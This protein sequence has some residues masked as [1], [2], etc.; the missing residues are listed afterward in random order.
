M[1][2]SPLVQLLQAQVNSSMLRST[3][4]HLLKNQTS[5]NAQVWLKREDEQPHGSKQRKYA[6][7]IPALLRQ[8]IKAVALLGSM[9]SN[10][11]V[12]IT[13]LLRQAGIQ[14]LLVLREG[15]ADHKA[16]NPLLLRLLTSPA[17]RKM[18]S[19]ADWPQAAQLAQEWLDQLGHSPHSLVLPEGGF[20]PWAL[21]GALTLGVELLEQENQLGFAFDHLVLDAGT[22]LTAAAL[23]LSGAL[24]GRQWPL[25][26]L[27]RAESPEA[28]ASRFW[29][30]QRWAA[31]LLPN[32][33]A[34]V[35][36]PI[37]HSPAQGKSFGSTTTAGLQFLVNF[38][39]SE[40]ILLDPIYNGPLMQHT[41]DACAKGELTGKVLVIHGGGL[42]ALHGFAEQLT[43]KTDI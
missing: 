20:H 9:G 38:S 37:F 10:H 43:S 2:T 26:V 7:L 21:A 18:V 41:L 17:E 29:E 39:Q 42:H 24:Q 13:Q 28:M 27:V 14:P 35:P 4:I 32:W 3:R 12:A 1:A 22:G 5:S 36:L 31:H 19:R 40:G 34:E 15:H 11:L 23:W 6:S 33:K 8:Q 25:Q 16:G 30:V